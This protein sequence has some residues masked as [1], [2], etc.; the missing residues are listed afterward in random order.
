MLEELLPMVLVAWVAAAL[1]M[2]ALWVIHFRIKNA[3]IVD[4]G[5]AGNFTLIAITCF[6]LTDGY[7]VRKLLMLGMASLWSRQSPF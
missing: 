1:V 7:I 4:V 3:A 5:W 6:L 2:L